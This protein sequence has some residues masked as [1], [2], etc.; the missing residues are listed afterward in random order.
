MENRVGEE[1]EGIVTSVTSFG[2]FVEL[3]GIF[4]EGLVHVTDLNN[5][6]YNYDPSNHILKGERTKQV[7]RLGDKIEVRVA[8]VDVLER[9]IDLQLS[10][11]KFA[12]QARKK[13]EERKRG[14]TIKPASR[15]KNK[16]KKKRNL[17][18]EVKRKPKLT[19]KKRKSKK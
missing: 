15:S 14:A 12:T 1:F 6:Y 17:S 5:D 2:L 10:G 13:E 11:S 3:E 4:I 16:Q 8:R 9:K 7:F 19:G 18:K